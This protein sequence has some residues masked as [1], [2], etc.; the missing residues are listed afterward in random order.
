M[1][2]IGR[3]II[4]KIYRYP[5]PFLWEAI[6][7][8]HDWLGEEFPCHGDSTLFEV[9]PKGEVATHLKEAGMSSGL[10]YLINI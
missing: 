2:D 10:S 6:T 3:F 8:I 1:P 7:A 5:E 9:I 4:V